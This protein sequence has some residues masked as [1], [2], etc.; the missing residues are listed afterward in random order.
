MAD[1]REGAKTDGPRRLPRGRHALTRDQVRADQ[2][3]RLV[4]AVPQAVAERGYEAMSVADVVRAAGVSRN[5]FYENFVD[6]HDCFAAA[7]EACH[8]LLLE[9]VTRSC[10]STASLDERVGAGLGAGLDLLSAEPEVARLLFVEA[11][12]AGDDVALRHHEWLRRYGAL[13]RDA[14]PRVA[15]RPGEAAE[16]DTIVLGG[17]ASRLGGEILRGGGTQLRLLIPS[18]ARYVLAFYTTDWPEPALGP[19]AV[20]PDG[21]RPTKPEAIRGEQQRTGV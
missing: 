1:A 6:K 20:P 18:L 12:A 19:E 13:L 15:A 9:V 10:R 7:F 3:R 21:A 11:F 17:V 8:E 4:E 2:R 16:I 5:A 14:S